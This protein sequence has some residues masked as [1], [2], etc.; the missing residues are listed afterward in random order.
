MVYGWR[1]QVVLYFILY[2]MKKLFS[3]LV[4]LLMFWTWAYAQDIQLNPGWNA[5]STP[6]Y[7]SDLTFSNGWEWISFTTLKDWSWISVPALTEN[8][9]PLEGFMVYNANSSTVTLTLDYKT[10]PTPAESIWQK[11]LSRWWNLLWITTTDDPFKWI[12]ATMFVDPTLWWRYTVSNWIS[13]PELGEA[14]FVFVSDWSIYGWVN[15]TEVAVNNEPEV[16]EQEPIQEVINQ[17]LKIAS[18][19]S[20]EQTV[21]NTNLIS[22]VKFRVKVSDWVSTISWFT[23]K[24][25]SNSNPNQKNKLNIYVWDLPLIPEE[26]DINNSWDIIVH[27]LHE[28][29]TKNWKTIE[30]WLWDPEWWS[31][32]EYKLTDV[33][34]TNADINFKTNYL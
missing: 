3:L 8:I 5:V 19:Q 14:Y 29:L 18:S 9:K 32:Y 31:S 17:E 28:E 1:W 22:I 12:D 26:Y 15:T 23:L 20:E 30:V 6:A 7:L 34:W 16:I 27:W 33:N 25:L 21:S 10:D 11:Q 24:W 2:N 4:W 13:N